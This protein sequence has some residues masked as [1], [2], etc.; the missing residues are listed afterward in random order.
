MKLYGHK[1]SS[2]S[3]SLRHHGPGYRLTDHLAL[4][5]FASKDGTDLVLVHDATLELFE[6]VRDEFGPWS[7]NSAFRSPAHHASIYARIGQAVK[8]GSLH[9]FGMALDCSVFGARP[10]DVARWA[11]DTGIGGIGLYRTFVHLDVGRRRSWTGPGVS[12]PHWLR[13]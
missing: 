8:W 4:I 6:A 10:L 11:V 12:M 13:R 5:E 7:P 2:R 3:Y 1:N 9:L